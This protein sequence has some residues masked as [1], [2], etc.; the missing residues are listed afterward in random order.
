MNDLVGCMG[1]LDIARKF[2]RN[3][4]CMRK[5]VI[6]YNF[7]GELRKTNVSYE[8]GHRVMDDRN[9]TFYLTVNSF[10]FYLKFHLCVHISILG[11][12]KSGVFTP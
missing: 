3:G 11:G 8:V 9:S 5:M 10:N 6:F 4:D 7:A 1:F 2:H 12:S